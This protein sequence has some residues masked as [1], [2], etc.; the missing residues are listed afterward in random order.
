MLPPVAAATSEPSRPCSSAVSACSA[1][2]V[3][4]LAPTPR[5]PSVITSLPADLADHV[6]LLARLGGRRQVLVVLTD[7]LARLVERPLQ[8]ARFLLLHRL[9]HRHRHD[10]GVVADADTLGRGHEGAA[11]RQIGKQPAG[12]LVAHHL[13]AEL[14]Q[15]TRR[16]S[17][18]VRGHRWSAVAGRSGPPWCRAGRRSAN[19]RGRSPR[20]PRRRSSRRPRRCCEP[21]RTA[22]PWPPETSRPRRPAAPAPDWRRGRTPGPAPFDLEPLLMATTVRPIMSLPLI[23][24]NS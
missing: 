14:P 11:T 10:G 1:V 2:M 4:P 6:F 23:M 15:S 20:R 24:I 9:R 16:R 21:P 17:C 7:V 22:P 8:A 19:R 3:S 5:R 13:A 18:R 12:G